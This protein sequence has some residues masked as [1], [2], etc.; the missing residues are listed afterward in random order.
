MRILVT[1]YVWPSLKVEER[2]LSEIGATLVVAPDGNEDTLVNLASGCDGILTCWAKTSRRVIEAALPQLKVIVRYGV[3][4]DNIDVACATEKGI[5]VANVPD[6]CFVDVAEH[7]LA[8]LLSM[9]HKVARF[10]RLVR[11][12][13]WSIQ[14]G[15]PLRRL[16]GQRLG[17]IGFGQIAR[18]V[19]PRAR[20]FGMEVVA[21]S[22]S[23]TPEWALP[24]GVES[25]DLDTLV[26]TCDF[27]SIH[28]PSTDETRGMIGVDVLGKMKKTACLINTSRGDIVDEEA[29]VRA[30]EAGQIAGAALDVR[31][32]EPPGAADRLIQMEQVIHTPHA[33]FYSAE[34]MT[35]LPEKAAWEVRRVLTGEVPIHLVNPAYAKA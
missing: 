26:K 1:D 9:S 14:S 10:D 4:L 25:V 31:C 21:F 30:L 18:E 32:Q 6:Y 28:C 11:S 5:P 13:T 7:T 17:L 20:A 12:G 29:L 34:S 19:V 8:L 15:L 16:M 23:L 24:A 2:I 27:V 35:E 3:G 33:A 22:R